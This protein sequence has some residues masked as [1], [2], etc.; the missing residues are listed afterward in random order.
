MSIPCPTSFKK[1]A[2]KRLHSSTWMSL[3]PPCKSKTTCHIHTLWSAIVF[4]TT[5]FLPSLSWKVL[6]SARGQFFHSK[7]I[8]SNDA[9]I[10][11]HPCYV[12]DAICFPWS[13]LVG[14]VKY[15]LS[16]KAQIAKTNR[17]N[18]CMDVIY[19]NHIGI[20]HDVTCQNM[21]CYGANMQ[22]IQT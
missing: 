1:L 12:F 5:G 18:V 17:W 10:P 20:R 21:T 9:N 14:C 3:F 22:N 15:E 6:C 19:A 8:H 4:N 16:Y 2:T 13:S 7:C 11:N